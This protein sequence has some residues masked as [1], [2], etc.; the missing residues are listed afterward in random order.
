MTILS[1]AIV[2]GLNQYI[3]SDTERA[4]DLSQI[5]GKTIKIYLKELNQNIIL[6]INDLSV[7]ELEEPVDKTD[8]EV[9][10]SL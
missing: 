8:V 2:S 5:N 7:V 10:V 3:N 1:N 9:I 4:R 6:K